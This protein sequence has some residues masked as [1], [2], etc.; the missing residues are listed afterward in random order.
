MKGNLIGIISLLA[1]FQLACVA[2]FLFFYRRGNLRSNRLLG[3]VFMLFSLSL[4]DFTIRVSGIIFNNQ[5]LHLIDDG[6]FF[7]YGPLL[8]FYVRSVVYKDFKF[9]ARDLFH[10]I[11]FIIFFIYVTH[12]IL[13]FD[14]SVKNQVSEKI[15]DADLPVWMYLTSIIIYALIFAY[16][17]AAGRTIKVYRS[18]VKNKF[19][20]MHE[21]NLNWMVF[22]IRSFAAI[23]LI[24]MIHNVTPV[25][26]NRFILYASLIFLIISTFLFI[27]YVL[28]KALKQSEIFEGV[29]HNDEQKYVGSLLGENALREYYSQLKDILEREKLYL[30]PELTIKD[31]TQYLNAN[32]KVVSQVINQCS[33]MS[34][35]DFIN[36]YRCEEVKHLI[37]TSEPKTT[38]LELMYQAGFNSKSSFNKEFKKLTG[39]TPTEYKRSLR[40]N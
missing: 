40:K 12:S 29:S 1:A 2:F 9:R 38:V 3:M 20:S 36:T 37:S 24:A 27:N 16:I 35:F 19:S 31:L 25:F 28:V 4:G 13:S 32:T 26:D 10:L 17:W 11:P 6:S 7:L 23:T 34:F 15:L 21:I 8:F 22:I 30:N 33:G 18:I 14:P 5:Y 39:Q